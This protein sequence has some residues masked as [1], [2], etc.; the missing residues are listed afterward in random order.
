MFLASNAVPIL[1][2]RTT[3]SIQ[4]LV[5]GSKEEKVAR[6]ADGMDRTKGFPVPGCTKV[7]SM[8]LY[9]DFPSPLPTL[10]RLSGYSTSTIAPPSPHSTPWQA[11]KRLP[12][13]GQVVPFIH[14]PRGIKLRLPQA[15]FCLT[16]CTHTVSERQT[17]THARRY[18]CCRTA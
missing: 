11:G 7:H 12:Y 8:V 3:V 6:P 1:A 5:F 16:S 17:D 13:L 4:H 2:L 10:T 9:L 18:R 14:W 15:N